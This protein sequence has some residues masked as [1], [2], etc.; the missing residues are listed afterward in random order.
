MLTTI[1]QPEDILEYFFKKYKYNFLVQRFMD[2]PNKWVNYGTS[3][4]KEYLKEVGVPNNRE[5]FPDE[6]VIDIDCDEEKPEKLVKECFNEITYR[7]KRLNINFFAYKSGGLGRHISLFFPEL[8]NYSL[9]QRQILK[10]IFLKEIGKGFIYNKDNKAHVCLANT[11]MI[12]LEFAKHRKGGK[13]ILLFAKTYGIPRLPKFI[14]EKYNEN[15]DK[16]FNKS[17]KTIN[18]KHIPKCISILEQED[19]LNIKDGR[20]RALFI[21]ALFYSYRMDKEDLFNKLTE[22]N[23]YKLNNHLSLK[24]IKA[25]IELVYK[26]RLPNDGLP[27]NYI[28]TLFDELNLELPKED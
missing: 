4:Y 18:K 9:F 10:E 14:L 25:N 20:A 2:F 24:F 1:N 7:L 11:K 15:K 13:K 22:W 21:L 16:Y 19:F 17:L 5:R 8:L 28:R 12:Q 6:I 27:Y 23:K 26:K 3:E